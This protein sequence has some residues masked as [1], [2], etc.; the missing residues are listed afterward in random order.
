MPPRVR[1]HVNPYRSGLLG[2]APQRLEFDPGPIEVELGCADAQFLFQLAALQPNTNYVGVEI[3]RPLVD[4]VNRRARES[5][6]GRLRAVYAHI[7]IDLPALFSALSVRR[8]YIN[9]P[10][11]WFKRAQ[12]KRRILS[13]EV[14]EVGALL[15]ELL[16]PGGELFF[17]SDVFDLALDAM[18]VLETL[19]NLRNV[20]GEWC[21][22]RQNPFSARSLREDRVSE[23]AK[24]V[25]RML[26]QRIDA[27]DK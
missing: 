20:A 1:H 23:A 27:G 19:P 25:W 21:F 10:D 3:R 14:P 11:P 7:N 6:L 13:P 17:Q 24:P 9:F 26:Y 22:L 12:R 15:V 4:D 18:A 8:F 16:E 2:I 5:G